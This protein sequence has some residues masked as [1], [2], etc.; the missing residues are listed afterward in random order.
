MHA[1]PVECRDPHGGRAR[2]R[3]QGVLQVAVGLLLALPRGPTCSATSRNA[4]PASITRFAIFL[5]STVNPSD[6]SITRTATSARAMASVARMTLKYSTPC[7]A[8]L[9]THPGGVD[10]PHRATRPLDDRVHGVTGGAGLLEHH[11]ALL[12]YQAVEQARLPDV[13]PTHQGEPRLRPAAVAF[14]RGVGQQRHDAIE[15]LARRAPVHRGDLEGLAETEPMELGGVGLV[16]GAVHLVGHEEHR[17]GGASQ[18]TCECEVLFGD[19]GRGIDDEEDQV[20]VGDGALGLLACFLFH[21]VGP[22]HVAGG[23]HQAEPLAAP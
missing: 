21:A 9:T 6:A 2:E 8:G 18:P 23:V 7:T 4:R 17:H 1:P 3:P 12:P 13:G 14:G 11:R 10:E 20:R 16:R 5:S 22:A 19:P 15:E